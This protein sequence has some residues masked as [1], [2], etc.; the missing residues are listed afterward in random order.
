MRLPGAHALGTRDNMVDPIGA[1]ALL[2]G[3]AV[4]KFEIELVLKDR[5]TVID[6]ANDAD[7]ASNLF[8]EAMR[9]YPT[10]HIRMRCGTEI[11]SERMPPRKP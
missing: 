8:D 11:V 6:E 9:K 4:R 2:K 1:S 7:S 10:R 5:L 3:R